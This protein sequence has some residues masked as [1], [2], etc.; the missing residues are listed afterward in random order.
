MWIPFLLSCLGYTLGIKAQLMYLITLPAELSFPSSQRVCLDL[1]GVDNSIHVVLTLVHGS[2]NLSL[3]N[4]VVRNNWIFECSRFQ[5]PK[6]AGSQEVGTVQMHISNGQ[7]FS[8]KEEKQVLIRRAGTGTFIQ[9]EK[10]VYKPG[11]TVKFRIV[12][13][14]EDFV[15]VNNKYS[16]VEVQDPHGN[17]IGQWLDV[18]PKQGIADLTFQLASEVSVGTYK[19]NIV[20]PKASSTFRVEER[21]L[22]KFDVFFEGPAQIYASDKTFLLRVCGRYSYGKAVKGTM[23]VTLCQKA[24]RCPQDASRDICR[25]YS[26]LT[27]SKGCFTSSVSTAVFNMSP[28]EDDSKIYAE[29]SLLEEGTGVQVNTSS[30]IVISRT[31]ARVVFETPNA[32]YTPGVPFEGKIKLQ[33]HYGNSMKNRKVN[34]IVRFMKRQLIKTYITDDSG[35]ASFN[36]DTTAW[37]SSSVSLEGR[38]T[39]ENVKQKPWKTSISYTNAYHHLQ[40]FHVTT[41]SFLKIHSLTGKLPCGLKQSVQVTF[42]LSRADVGDNTNRI[43]FAYYVTGKA[44]IVNRGRRSVQVGKLNMLKGSFFIPLTFTADFTPSPCLVVYTIFPN[45]GVTADSTC[46]DV[47]LCFENQVKVDFPTKE[48]YAG[49]IVQLQL[50]AAPGSMCAV[51]AVDENMFLIRPESELTSEKVYGLF[52]AIYRHGYPAQVEEHSDH[53]I[54]PQFMSSGLQGKPQHPFQ[55]DIFN[56]FWNMGLK[57]FSNLVIKKP[58]QCTQRTERKPIMGVPSMEDQRITKEQ[59]QF[60]TQGRFHNS[61]SETWIWNLFFVGSN[62]SR[63]VPVKVPD[64]VTKWK[65]KMFCLSGR[66]FGLAPTM[67]L[68]TIQPVFVDVTLPYSVIRGETFMLKATVFNYLQQCLQIHVALGKSLDFQVERCQTCRDRECLCVEE[69][70][71]FTWNVTATQLGTLN[72]T[73]RTEVLDTTPRCG[74]RK[75]LPATMR[76][77]HALIKHLLVRPE[78]VLVEKSHNSLLCPRGGNMAE[79]PMLIHLPDNAVEGS[80]SASVSISGDLMGLALQNL[81]RLVQMPHGC[82]EQNMVLFT[83]IVYVLQYLEKTRQLTPVIK[84]RATGLLHNA[85]QTQLLYKRRDG[86]YS[87]FGQQDGEGNTWLTAFV[88][89]S[90]GQG[91][92]YIY[93]DDK[94]IQDALR[95]LEQNQLPSGCFAT[96][97]NL[98]HSSLKGSLDDEISLGAYIAAA[99][100]ELGEPLKGKLMQATF[101]CL[102][103]SVHNITNTYTRAV[104]AYAFALAG[105]YEKTQEL[106]N[107]LEE[108]AI[109]SG[110]QIHWSPKTSS[111]ASTDFWHSTQSVDV[112]LT[113]YVLLAYLS[114]PRLQAR[115][116]TTAAGI[117]AWLTQQQNAYGGFASTQDTVVALQALAKYASRMF[118]TSGQ[119]LV[120]MKSQRDFGKTF[121]ITRQKRLL[122]QHAELT[123]IPG[124]FLVQVQGRSCVFAQMVLRYHEPTPQ[125]TKTFSLRVNTKLANCS[126]A[127]M[128]FLTVHI[129][130]SYTGSRVTSNMVIMEVSL[131]SGFVLASGSRMLLERKS[132]I[133]KVEVKA[134]VIYIY[135]DKLSDKS[136]TFILQLEQ[137][138]KV[139]NLKPT[140]IKIYDY[141][142]PEERALAVYSAVCS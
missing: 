135:L 15:P 35:R 114:K 109:K 2:G 68:R 62:G 10:P 102:H 52:P 126:Q 30:Q 11:Q 21:V 100:L 132:I 57:V 82:G 59:P 79:E 9:I 136:Q 76:R 12:T 116:M 5:V 130:S 56:I 38:F 74:G 111:P 6:P 73:I 72:I 98:F 44:G 69:S 16:K 137:M 40:P 101:S 7:Y 86:S 142:Q 66:T 78:G 26:G 51:Q 60:T 131:L 29:A 110:G 48:S 141:Y 58:T 120:K 94:N 88:A 65:V 106:L 4:K 105:D 119:A 140:I 112:E 125:T 115:D 107:K 92:K 19:I 22:Q 139:K 123:E 87:V 89:K 47:A 138:I 36:L 46:F 61:L 54:Q 33:D 31:A 39:L 37:N 64:A 43:D 25:E 42:T 28:S 17:R 18:R 121:Q 122:V 49:S 108:Q 24:K 134:D 128:H 50:Q 45:G 20:N 91:K 14:T 3:Y 75:P 80:A 71:T 32:Y 124:Q 97:G 27:A 1:R 113:A 53:C 23:W 90:F 55:P 77:T 8:T 83:P 81:D 41:R 67:S 103:H 85:Y 93:I 99:L 95:W 34:L 118:S 96:K 127:N 133:K 63:S 13:L 70:K 117:V 84:E 104:L 129:L